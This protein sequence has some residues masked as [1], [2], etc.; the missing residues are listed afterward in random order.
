MHQ[1]VRGAPSQHP[2][3]DGWI[4]VR[5]QALVAPFQLGLDLE[6]WHLGWWRDWQGCLGMVSTR[7]KCPCEL[8]AIGAVKKLTGGPNQ[9]LTSRSTAVI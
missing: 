3:P 6:D 7:E 2:E 5:L 4:A 9:S 8:A 1:L